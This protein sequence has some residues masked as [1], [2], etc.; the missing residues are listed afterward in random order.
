MKGGEA[1]ETTMV[2]PDNIGAVRE[3][4]LALLDGG[5]AHARFEEAVKAF[6]A[7]A[8][9]RRPPNV[10]YTPWHLLEHIRLAQR[11]IL[12][13]IRDPEYQAP[14]WPADYWPP[15]VATATLDGLAATIEA[16]TADRAA[17]RELVLDPLRDPFAI[18]PGTPNHTL[19]R[20]I[21]IV[22]D[23]NAFHLGEFTI[24][25]AVMGTW[26]ADHPA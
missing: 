12:D 6:P 18:I 26:P 3:G 16:F 15:R 25:R 7:R 5:G 19:A 20:E 4:L 23:H 21:R 1:M 11:D 13:Y 2:G 22:A 8:I 9:N 14:A 24:L 17:L 10:P